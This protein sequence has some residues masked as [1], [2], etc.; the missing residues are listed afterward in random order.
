[1]S[2]TSANFYLSL[3]LQ[4][5]H[6]FSPLSVAVHLLPQAI[7]GILV[8]VFAG[9]FLHKISNKILVGVGSFAYA[10][11]AMLLA[12]Q[13]QNSSYWAFIFPSLI[14]SVVGA[15]LQFNVANVRSSRPPF[16]QT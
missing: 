16:P 15:D 7:A 9:M 8:N 4:D 6:D 2:F 13:K 5:V 10:M 14:L 1:M 11:A 12:L 3:Y